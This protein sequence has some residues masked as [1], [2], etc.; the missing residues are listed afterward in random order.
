MATECDIV[1]KIEDDDVLNSFLCPKAKKD[2][3]KSLTISEQIK[4]LSDGIDMVSKE[5]QNQVL[6][7]HGDLIRQAA[8]ANNL[9]AILSNMNTHM[10]NLLTNAEPLQMHTTVLSRLHLASHILRQVNRVQ[11]SSR[12]LA[13]ISDP[14]QKATILQELEQLTADPLLTDV[15]VVT[16]EL[17][18]IRTEQQK[19]VKLAT[20]SLNQGIINGNVAQTTTAL[21]IFINLGTIKTVTGNLTSV[22]LNECKETLKLALDARIGMSADISKKHVGPGR[23]NISSSQGFKSRIWTDL[24]KTF[25]DDIYDQCKQV[26]F[27]QETLMTFHLHACNDQIASNFWNQLCDCLVQEINNSS[28]AVRQLL[29]VDYPKLLKLYKDLV[30]KLN[31][32][33]FYFKRNILEKWENTYLSNTLNKLLDATQSMFSQETPVPSHDQIDTL[34]RNITNE[35]SVALVEDC[36]NKKVAKNVAKC[37]RMFAVKTEQQLVTG[38][39]AAQVIGGTPNSS[40]LHNIKLANTMYY[41]R[42][43]VDRMLINMKESLSLNTIDIVSESLLALDNLTAGIIQ[44][45]TQSI[46]STIETIIITIHLEQDWVKLQPPSVRSNVSCSPYMRE[47]TQ[48]I[49]R[50][51]N[52]YL[53]LFENKEVLALKC[54]DIV[55][56]CIDLLVRHTSLIRPISQGGRI[57][58]QVDYIN[59][60]N[61]L[62]AFYPYLSDLG[63]PYRLLKSMATLITLTPEEIIQKQISGSSVP[64]STVLFLLFS[65]AGNDLASPHQNASWS[66]SKISSWLDEHTL[67]SDRYVNEDLLLVKCLKNIFRLDLIAGALQRYENVIR[68]KNLSSYDSV[69]PLIKEFFEYAVTENSL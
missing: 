54:N 27:L 39:D 68:I 12:R 20:T 18:N 26:K 22:C 45:L 2:L 31:F 36:L 23:A 30:L 53:N 11:Q 69:Y 52:T 59:L 15:D 42:V 25:S 6:S 56:R 4:K 37:I 43:Q 35:L 21:Q 29:E 28:A 38:S 58:V 57:R 40:Q 10:E 41:F 44:P 5:L 16:S 32:D 60:E 48:F 65:F 47:L 46:N 7:R 34:I 9:E 61:A 17:R 67:E 66:L 33:H 55:L 50:V 8:H 63:R 51:N 62:K 64:H 14:I 3:L 13:S 24:E 19:V 1:N 49:L